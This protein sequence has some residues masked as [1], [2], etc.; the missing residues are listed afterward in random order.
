MT[1]PLSDNPA[2]IRMR[3]HRERERLGVR[4]V[5]IEITPELVSDLLDIGMLELSEI[6]D[7]EALSRA[8]FEMAGRV[9]E[10]AKTSELYRKGKGAGAPMQSAPAP[11]DR[12]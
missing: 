3:R 4:L 5:E 2:A 10:E 7:D 8:I 9:V 6:D 11:A 12:G 1:R